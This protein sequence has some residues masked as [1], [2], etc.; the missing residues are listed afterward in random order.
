MKRKKETFLDLLEHYFSSYL[1]V[2][3]GLSEATIVSYKATFRIFMEYM[4]SV[5][6]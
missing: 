6:D 1:P 2:A 3:K 5:K 4:Y